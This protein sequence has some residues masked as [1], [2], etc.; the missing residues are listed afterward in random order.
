MKKLSI[1]S[2]KVWPLT[3]IYIW[4]IILFSSLTA[5]VRFQ[6]YNELKSQ[7]NSVD[8]NSVVVVPSLQL[9]PSK[10]F[11]YPWTLLTATLVQTSIFRLIVSLVITFFGIEYLQSN[12]TAANIGYSSNKRIFDETVH[13]LFV[14]PLVTNI[15]FVLLKSSLAVL[16]LTSSVSLFHPINYG[17]YSVVMSFVVVIKQL[18]PEYNVKLFK[19]IKFRLKRLP[20][21]ILSVALFVSIFITS[22]LDPFFTPL[23]INFYVS[24]CYLRYYQI[25]YV[26]DILPTTAGSTTATTSSSTVRGDASDTFA[27][28]QFFPDNWQ[29]YLKPMSRFFYHS[30]VFLGLFRP[31]NDD[32]IESSNL[33]TIQRL[34][35]SNAVDGANS[36][37]DSDRRKRVALK[38]LEQRV[39]DKGNQDTTHST[40][41]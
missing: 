35:K 8:S 5:Y 39:A 33:R 13:Y 2:F 23:F 27:F 41:D 15:L 7:S 30:S 17:I 12:W 34:N 20:F 28:I 36:N 24:W 10:F 26:G 16:G 19:V 3:I 1:G 32:D 25:S 18:S 21:I 9:V 22:S 29:R 6:S 38:V 37:D 4:L 40:H 31:F 14:V 11:L